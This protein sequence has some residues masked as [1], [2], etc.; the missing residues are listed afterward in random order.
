MNRKDFLQSG[1][2]F[3]AA[4][5]AFTTKTTAPK[6]HIPPYLKKG[7]V[8]GITCPSGYLPADDVKAAVKKMEDW[9]FRIV[10][11]KTVGLKD[12]TLAGTDE[13]RA[14]DLQQMI[15]DKS[16]NAIMLGRGG[17]GAIRV[18]DQIDW[19]R[20]AKHPKWIMGFSD[21]TV[22]HL[23]LNNHLHIP[24]IHCKMC[25]SFP[26]DESMV[27]PDQ[28]DSIDSIR[29]SLTG[30]KMNYEA[31]TLL[32]NRKGVAEGDLVGG[33]LSIIEMMCGSASEIDTKNK[34]LFI[35]DVGEYMYKLDGMLW[36]LKRSGKLSKLKGLVVGGFRIKEDEDED[37]D[38]F[39][40]TLYD[41]VMEKINGYSYPVC[42]DF[43]VGHIRVNYA[44]KCGMP[45]RLEVNDSNARLI[46]LK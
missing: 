19:S 4:V 41:I 13:E 26:D 22:L 33:N 10:L 28:A 20:F 36:N 40:K 25:N 11:G 5:P 15:D 24:S 37:G 42:F 18:I 17:Y 27:S 21:A 23:H 35:E 14:A 44:L 43:P 46:S 29:R 32:E 9:G 34:I 3:L 7:D 39:G 31:C 16:V 2:P 12:F 38:G 30:E 45:H 6:K 1:I 8:I